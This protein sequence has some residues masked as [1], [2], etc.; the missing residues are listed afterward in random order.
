VIYGCEIHPATLNPATIRIIPKTEREALRVFCRKLIGLLFEALFW[1]ISS[2]CE[3]LLI[4]NAGNLFFSQNEIGM[5]RM[6][7]IIQAVIAPVS[8]SVGFREIVLKTVLLT[9]QFNM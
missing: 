6:A 8:T 9:R 2:F 4:E 7:I 3:K 1:R 5:R